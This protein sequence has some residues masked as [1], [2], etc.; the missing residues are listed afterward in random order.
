MPS[1]LV[2]PTNSTVS[3]QGIAIYNNIFVKEVS[4]ELEW[5]S[6]QPN[7]ARVDER[8]VVH[9]LSKGKANIT[10][11]YKGKTTKGTEV[12]VVDKIAE[13]TDREIK[14]QLKR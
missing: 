1:H 3:L 9:S 13:E 11:R 14:G 8:G 7:V 6:S 5:F 10:V 2:M 4:S 12:L